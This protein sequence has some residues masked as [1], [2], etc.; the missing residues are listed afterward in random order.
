MQKECRKCDASCCRYFSFQIDRPDSYEEFENIRWYLMHKGVSVHVDFDG[1]WYIRLDNRCKMLV[2]T[3]Q[4]PRCREYASRPIVCRRFAPDTCDFAAG[5]FA[6]D[7][8]FTTPQQLEAYARRML[9]EAEF[10]AACDA[11]RGKAKAGKKS[12]RTLQCR[13]KGESSH[14]KKRSG[15]RRRH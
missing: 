13:G 4:G 10:D 7:E 5:G 6:Y 15:P 1:D 3:P 14:G 2:N 11:V 9:G 8:L 12:P